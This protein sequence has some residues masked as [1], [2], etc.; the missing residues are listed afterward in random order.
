MLEK[1]SSEKWPQ[2]LKFL[3]G[4]NRMNITP[5]LQYFEPLSKFLDENVNSDDIG[6]NAKGIQANNWQKYINKS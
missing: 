2:Q 5:L 4:N 3:T 6:W 1:G